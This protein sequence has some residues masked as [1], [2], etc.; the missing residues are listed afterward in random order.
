MER[1]ISSKVE[2]WINQETGEVRQVQEIEV[3]ATD[4]GFDKVWLGMILAVLEIIGSKKI[5]VIKYILENRS[6]TENTI[7]VSQNK[8]AKDVGVSVQTVNETMKRLES[9]DFIHRIVPGHYRINPAVIWRG[10]H[11]GRMAI[12][13]KFNEEKAVSG[14]KDENPQQEPQKAKKAA[15]GQ[16]EADLEQGTLPGVSLPQ[17]EI[18]E[19][20]D[21]DSGEQCG[22]RL[23]PETRDDGIWHVCERCGTGT[24]IRG[25][26]CEYSQPS[27]PAA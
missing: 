21:P 3:K 16:K 19:E 11:M 25:S 5:D 7:T 8:I 14:Q 18:C 26:G 22:G 1:K 9:A 2:T 6:R 20:I 12:M 15:S 13:A 4:K 10:S 27:T 24:K 17:P 23:V